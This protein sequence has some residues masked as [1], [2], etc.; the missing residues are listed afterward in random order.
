MFADKT[1]SRSYL[2]RYFRSGRGTVGDNK[3]R[4]DFFRPTLNFSVNE[5]LYAIL[6]FVTVPLDSVVV[7]ADEAGG[8][9]GHS[10]TETRRLTKSAN[11]ETICD[12]KC[13]KGHKE[14]DDGVGGDAIRRRVQ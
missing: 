4:K 3:V 6:S 11:D 12:D 7:V 13:K 5:A 2:F 10:S 14:H 9:D 8:A 1:D